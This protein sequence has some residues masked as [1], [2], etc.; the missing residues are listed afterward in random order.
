MRPRRSTTQRGSAAIELALAIG[1][2]LLPVALLVITLPTWPE[3]QTVARAAAAEASR[4]VVLAA[5]WTEGAD[6]AEAAVAQAAANHGLDPADVTLELAGGLERGAS[7]TA[8]V[9]V[10]MPALVLPGLPP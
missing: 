5:S 7:V 8:R 10:E 4:A 6:D 2:L 3:R 1:L 9:T